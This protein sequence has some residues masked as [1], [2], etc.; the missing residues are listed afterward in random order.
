MIL[1]ICLTHDLCLDSAP[2]KPDR[3]AYP[4]ESLV[5]FATL[6]PGKQVTHSNEGVHQYAEKG[7]G[8]EGKGAEK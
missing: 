7:G 5:Q 2:H 1:L 8:V 4:G 6:K 3:I